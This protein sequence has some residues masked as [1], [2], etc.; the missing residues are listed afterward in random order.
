MQQSKSLPWLCTLLLFVFAVH[1]MNKREAGKK[2]F[3]INANII[4]A[5]VKK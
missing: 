3:P 5:I 1:D 4:P 2:H